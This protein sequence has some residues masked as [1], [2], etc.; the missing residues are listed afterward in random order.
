MDLDI[1]GEIRKLLGDLSG[2][3][4][5]VSL[6]IGRVDDIRSRA[7]DAHD[8]VFKLLNAE[9]FLQKSADIAESMRDLR[10]VIDEL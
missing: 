7:I 9:G 3:V 8:R 10:R 1:S 5:D 4:N 6:F 2:T